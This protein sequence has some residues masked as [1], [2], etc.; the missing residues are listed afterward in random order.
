M[1]EKKYRKDSNH[2][3]CL[4]GNCAKCERP[5]IVPGRYA[6]LMQSHPAQ[7]DA[8][9]YVQRDIPGARLAKMLANGQSVGRETS[10][11]R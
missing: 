10:H 8:S 6:H 4:C 11:R 3:R 7:K 5:I 1:A 2:Q 9:G